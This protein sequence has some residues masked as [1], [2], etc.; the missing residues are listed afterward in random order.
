MMKHLTTTSFASTIVKI[1]F[2]IINNAT[3]HVMMQ[4]IMKI[5]N[6]KTE[7]CITHV[8]ANLSRI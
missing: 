1:R 7:E 4:F 5:R 6:K 8:T 3:K 2:Y